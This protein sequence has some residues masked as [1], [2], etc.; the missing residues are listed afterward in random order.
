MCGASLGPA[1]RE[2]AQCQIDQGPL[3]TC[4]PFHPIEAKGLRK[5]TEA[6]PGS[7]PGPLRDWVS[8]DRSPGRAPGQ[9]VGPND[10]GARAGNHTLVYTPSPW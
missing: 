9:P 4:V 5:A 10:S 6:W 3:G 7:L 8:P 2:G 1:G